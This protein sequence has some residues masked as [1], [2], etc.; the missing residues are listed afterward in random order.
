MKIFDFEK[1]GSTYKMK[2]DIRTY[3]NGNLALSMHIH[4]EDGWEP[5][6]ILTVNLGFPLERDIAYIDTNNNGESILSWIIRNKLA[7]PTGKTAG[8]GY[9]TYPQYKFQETALREIDPDGYEKYLAD[10]AA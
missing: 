6:N 8:S 10:C 4:T 1:N 7:V 2:L 3:S 5:W 9:C